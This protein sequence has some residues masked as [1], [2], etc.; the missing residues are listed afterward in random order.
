MKTP[1][2]T[3]VFFFIFHLV[4]IQKNLCGL[5]LWCIFI[6]MNRIIINKPKNKT[7]DICK[8]E[9]SLYAFSSHLKHTHKISS[10]E[11]TSQ[12]GEFRKVTS[13]VKRK[14]NKIVCKLCNEQ[15]STV[16]MFT[17]LRDSHSKNLNDYINEHGE[18]RVNKLKAL[19]ILKKSNIK[20][21]CLECKDDALYN[22]EL[23]TD[24]AL[25]YH[26]KNHHN[27]SKPDYIIKNIL[28]GDTP[29]CKCGCNNSVEIL[30]Y[31]YPY[32]RNYISGHNSS[33]AT[34]IMYGK[35][36]TSESKEKM[37]KK[38]NDRISSAISNNIVLPWKT[39]TSIAKRGKTYSDN[40][41][42]E[43]CK[44]YN[45][46]LINSYEEQQNGLYKFK[47]TL[48]NNTFEQYHNSYFNCRVCHPYV[49][50]KYEEEILGFLQ[51]DLQLNVVKN[52]RKIFEGKHEIDLYLPD[53][54]IGIEFNGLFWHSE[55]GGGKLRNYHINKT[56]L[57]KE[58][59][60]RCIHI[61]EDVW[62]SKKEIIKSKLKHI[63]K[64]Q[65][66]V[67]YHAR[68]CSIREIDNNIK[69]IF[70]NDNHIQGADIS[71]VNI[72]CYYK[73][74]LVS[75][76]T[77]SKPN[78]SKG[79]KQKGQKMFELSR[80]ASLKNDI[81]I[82]TFSKLL[83]YFIKNHNP[84]KIITY[85]DLCWSRDGD[86][87]YIKNGFLFTGITPPNYWYTNDYK[88]KIHRFNFTKHKLVKMGMNPDL[89]E[90]EN[91]KL[92]GYDRIWDC[93]N[94]KYEYVMF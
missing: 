10:N 19:C 67:K 56:K 1:V 69:N 90:W 76:M 59:G 46:E 85:A 3:G 21:K 55:I 20:L 27:M 39:P 72:G 6:I 77:F 60:I 26:I 14:V 81:A 64:K 57:C 53:L 47:C 45:I 86:N 75:V 15:F 24:T 23:Y 61:F 36:H 84:K 82:G 62:L 50:S 65:I 63:L 18:F 68:K 40:L 30:N 16:G 78:I 33:G 54:K 28:N 8:K 22:K 44:L 4:D 80:F 87:V 71:T 73:D 5:T 94:L 38:A 29:K 89:S 7:C 12:Y 51:N 35:K 31:V 79:Q 25:S 2:K 92:N 11:Y 34:N 41:M 74:I 9:I 17:H 32:H 13:S 88:T 83:S 48:C 43:K 58:K 42:K 93:G 91:M 66:G 52:F 70:L 49:K 37:R